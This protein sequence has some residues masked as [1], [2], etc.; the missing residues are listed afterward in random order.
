MPDT[1]SV[2]LV[3]REAALRAIAAA[4]ELAA[5]NGL[6]IAAAVVDSGG[7]V[8]ILDRMD[9]A[10][11]CT[12]DLSI[13]KARTAAATM[14]STE[15]WFRTTQPGGADWGMNMALAGR[16]NAMPGGIP[17]VIDGEVVGAIGVSGGEAVQDAACAVAGAEAIGG[18]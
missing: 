5:E 10:A 6:A 18:Y 12:I 8:V 7:H 9:G 17:I 16:F 13:D 2:L 15:T 1:R 14:A 4:H 11:S 3:T